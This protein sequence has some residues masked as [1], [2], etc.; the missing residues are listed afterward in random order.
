MNM[1]VLYLILLVAAGVCFGVSAFRP[2][3][4]RVNFMALGLLLW[5]LVPLLQLAQRV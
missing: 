5:V 1:T 3:A 2:V 4:S